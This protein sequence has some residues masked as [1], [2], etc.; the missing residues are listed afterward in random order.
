MRNIC[1]SKNIS[2]VLEKIGVE[3]LRHNGT[4]KTF[5]FSS[6]C[7]FWGIFILSVSNVPISTG[8]LRGIGEVFGLSEGNVNFEPPSRATSLTQQRFIRQRWL[9][10]V[11]PKNWI[12]N[13]NDKRG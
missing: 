1:I 8:I 7:S 6:R 9:F 12:T 13:L 5:K 4:E 2:Q 11:P 3:N 10:S